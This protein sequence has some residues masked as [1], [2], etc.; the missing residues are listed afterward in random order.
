MSKGYS[1]LNVVEQSASAN[2]LKLK[3]QGPDAAIKYHNQLQ[4]A[5]MP[6]SMKTVMNAICEYT[7]CQC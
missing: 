2:E 1:N 7:A 4:P 6:A 5:C 3:L